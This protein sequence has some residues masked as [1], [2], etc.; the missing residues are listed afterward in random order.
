MPSGADVALDAREHGDALEAPLSARIARAC[1]SARGFVEAVRHR[2]RPAVIGDGDV[3][4]PG[5]PRRERHGL[6]VGA[7]VGGGR[8]H[9]QIAAQVRAAAISRGSAAAF[10]GGDFAAVLA[11][12]RGYE[13]RPSAS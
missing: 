3:L 9:V 7:A 4:E 1:S 10:R 5:S 6:R 2:E 12:L 8:V 13:A 11:Q